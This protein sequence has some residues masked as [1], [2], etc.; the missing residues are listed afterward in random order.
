MNKDGMYHQTETVCC[1]NKLQNCHAPSC[2]VDS[3]TVLL[4]CT[5]VIRNVSVVSLAVDLQV[6]IF[7]VIQSSYPYR[8]HCTPDCNFKFVKEAFIRS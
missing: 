2:H 4:S 3:G 7:S 1:R 8:Q 6:F 5:V